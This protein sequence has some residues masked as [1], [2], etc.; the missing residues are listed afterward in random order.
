MTPEDPNGMYAAY[1]KLE[2]SSPAFSLAFYEGMETALQQAI[3]RSPEL[4]Q[5]LGR[6]ANVG[7]LHW[8]GWN[9]IKNEAVGHSS[10]DLTYDLVKSSD[11]PTPESVLK[12]FK[13]KEYFTEG[14]FGN[15]LQRFA[16]PKSP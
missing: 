8:K 7:G 11:D 4:K 3:D 5:V 1:G 6:H 9:A 14:L 10:L 16:L 12:L 13:N 2:G 15:S